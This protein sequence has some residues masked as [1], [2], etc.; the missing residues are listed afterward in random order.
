MF[1]GLLGF[2][3]CA[4]PVHIFAFENKTGGTLGK[5]STKLRMSQL[6]KKK[7]RILLNCPGWPQTSSPPA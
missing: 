1:I 7:K 3:F 4:V 5:C 6:F 2:L